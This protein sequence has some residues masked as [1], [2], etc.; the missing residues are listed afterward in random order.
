MTE[1]EIHDIVESQ[2]S[3]FYSGATLSIQER[4]HALQKLKS[5]I[6]K[7][8]G[9][10]HSAIKADLGKSAFESY[11]CET[12]LVLSEIRYMQKHIRS[13]AREKNVLTPLAQFHS[14]SYKKPSPYGVVLIMSPWNYPFLL[15]IEP[16]VDALAAGNTAVLKP[17][18][19]SP[20]TSEIIRRIIKECFSEKYVA[21]ITGGREENACLLKE[22]FDNIFFTGSQAVGKEVMKYAS[23]H[24]TPVTLE[25]GGKSPC[26]VDASANIRLAARRIV[27]GK[28]L[29]CGQTCVAPDYILCDPSIHD[30]LVKAICR[31]I[32]K[33]FGTNPLASANYGKIINDKHFQR[34]TRLIDPAKVICGGKQDAGA[35]KIEPT[36]MDHVTFA[37]A[38]MQEEIFGPVLPIL[39][40]TSLD[41][42]IQQINSMPHPLAFYLFS[43]DRAAIRKATARCGFGGGCIND[44][45]IHLATSH[46]GFGGF[47]ESGMGSYHGKDGFMTFSHDKSIVDK[48]TWIDLPM[49]YQP[50]RTINSKLIHMFLK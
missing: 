47:G 42:A 41:N 19:Y 46:M 29:N 44:T 16:L 38:V 7:Y 49:R 26:I 17:S 43:S 11:M 10:I 2:R 18:A 48:K 21:V 50:Y 4:L 12:G 28:F 27:F 9:E 36:V 14:R 3:Y 35:L 37:D 20:H 13:F 15:T 6:Q 45:I 39:T 1:Q 22:H 33:Q 8:E 25:L 40:Y 30:K 31:Q 34:I 23:E 24:L 5:Y 32:K